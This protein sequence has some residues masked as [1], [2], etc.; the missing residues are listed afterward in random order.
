MLIAVLFAK[1]QTT[2]TSNA[3]ILIA[4]LGY[5]YTLPRMTIPVGLLE[6]KD[7]IFRHIQ[8]LQQLA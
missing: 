2:S 4:G 5:V 1:F 8:P 6:E 7:G 3:Q